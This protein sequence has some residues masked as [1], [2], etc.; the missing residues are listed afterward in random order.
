MDL[1][2]AQLSS[3]TNQEVRSTATLSWLDWQLPLFVV[4]CAIAG[5]I[6]FTF[7]VSNYNIKKQKKKEKNLIYNS[8]NSLMNNRKLR[9]SGKKYK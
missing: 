3:R 1:Q 9:Y 7:L 6:L 8:I 5:A 4:L 2:T